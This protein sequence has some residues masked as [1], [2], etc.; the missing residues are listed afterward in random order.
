M[1]VKRVK[2]VEDYFK[3]KAFGMLRPAGQGFKYPYL[4]PGE[5]YLAQLWDWDSYFAAEALMSICEYFRKDGDF[6]YEDKRAAVTAAA[7]GCVLNFLDIQL[8]DGFI[9]ITVNPVMLEDGLWIKEHQ[10]PGTVNQHKPFLCGSALNVSRYCNDYEWFD[11]EKM[12]KYLDY[13]KRNQWHERTGL[14]IFKSDYMIGIDNNPSVYGW[15]YGSTADIYLNSFMYKELCAF[16]ELLEKRKDPR[17]AHYRAEAE[18]L[19][20]A[21]RREC[22]DPIDEFY[23]SVFI[24]LGENHK[25]IIHSGMPVFWNSLPVKLR[26]VSSFLP[27]YAGIATEKQTS[28]II[29]KYYLSPE[30]LSPYGLRSAAENE[31]FYCLKGTSNPSNSLGPVWVIYNY[32]A[33]S[34]LLKAGRI[35]LARDLLDRITAVLAAD[36]EQSGKTDECYDP[37]TG[38]PIMGKSFVSWNALIIKMYGDMKKYSE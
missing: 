3:T 8:P 4:D 17:A 11:A 6:G 21:V 35:R 25:G 37:N 15:P 10:S 1:D 5:Q 36:V 13:Y 16:A 9:P 29:D 23:Y 24:R 38:K 19:K 18:Q 14:Y 30:F 22:Y 32:F 28:R 2:I 33:F 7:K 31:R 20:A 12:V 26:H 34:F 27:L